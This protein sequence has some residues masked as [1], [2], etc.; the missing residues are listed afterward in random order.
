MNAAAENFLAFVEQKVLADNRIEPSSILALVRDIRLLKAENALLLK[1]L[2]DAPHDPRECTGFLVK[3][4][5]IIG[6]GGHCDCW[7]SRIPEA[8]PPHE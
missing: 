1:A 2:E 4:G 6:H 7:K 8:K 5:E 3:S